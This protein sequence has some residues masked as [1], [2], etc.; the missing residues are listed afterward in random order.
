MVSHCSFKYHA[1]HCR[2]L[3]GHKIATVEKL[4][5]EEDKAGQIREVEISTSRQLILPK[6]PF[7][8]GISADKRSAKKLTDW[9]YDS[10][11]MYGYSCG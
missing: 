3:A 10:L 11:S 6:F 7:S 9:V 5:Y 4:K 1:F 2:C 8:V